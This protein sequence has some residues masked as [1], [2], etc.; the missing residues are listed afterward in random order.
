MKKVLSALVSS[1]LLMAQT[2]AFAHAG[3]PNPSEASVQSG[4]M[5][6]VGVLFIPMSLVVGG[7]AVANVSV[8]QLHQVL[9]ENTRW[10]VKGMTTQGDRTELVLQSQDGTATLTVSVPT[11]Q[12]DRARVAMGQTLVAKQL[13]QQGFAL[14]AGDVTLGVIQ[15][16]A[17]DLSH[18]RVKR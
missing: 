2:G 13:G 8:K 7:S 12:F 18:S 17:A 11:A 6:S 4:A 16:S 5:L 10:T 15:T 9:S 1:A 14:K 3:Q